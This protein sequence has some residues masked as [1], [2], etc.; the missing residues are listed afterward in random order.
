MTCWVLGGVINQILDRF[1]VDL[2]W[3]KLIINLSFKFVLVNVNG[4]NSF[5]SPDWLLLWL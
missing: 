5:G 3:E 1:L 2:H 4:G